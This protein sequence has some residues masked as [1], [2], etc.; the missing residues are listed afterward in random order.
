MKKQKIIFLAVL[1]ILFICQNS[2][3]QNLLE[4]EG[5]LSMPNTA[6]INVHGNFVENVADHSWHKMQRQRRM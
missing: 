4:V 6:V 3:S 5:E 2:W 1:S